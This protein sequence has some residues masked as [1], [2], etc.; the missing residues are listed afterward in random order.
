MYSP[1]YWLFSLLIL[2]GLGACRDNDSD[3]PENKP[4]VEVVEQKTVPNIPYS[5]VKYHAHDTSL[6]T[7]GL[8][9]YKGK[10][11]ESTGSPTDLAGARSLIGITDLATGKFSS[12]IEL[13]KA[14]YFGEG[15]VFF[16]DKLYQLTYKNKTGFIYDAMTFK[17]LG[18]FAYGNAE[19]WGMTTDGSSL[20][21]SDGTN[22]LTYLDPQSLKPTKSLNVTESGYGKGHLNELEYIKGFIYANVWMTNTIVK[23]NP[24]NGEVVGT[25]N[26]GSLAQE[27]AVKNPSVDVLNGIAYDAA[28]D[29]VYVA[30][31]LWPN[32]YQ[33][34]FE[35]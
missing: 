11:Y 24:A 10:L 33:I 32:I 22:V 17:R 34:A 16:N 21:M 12:K 27:A 18:E 30:G 3:T 35:Y 28:T 15:I 8:V 13:D 31:K 4:G 29:K 2:V 25:M 1:K 20:I 9:F 5:V 14:K 7:E 26:L 19:G 23:I 6:F